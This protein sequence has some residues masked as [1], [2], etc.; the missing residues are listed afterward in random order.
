MSPKGWRVECVVEL[1]GRELKTHGAVGLYA[2]NPAM[3]QLEAANLRRMLRAQFRREKVTGIDVRLSPVDY[4]NFVSPIN[5][6]HRNHAPS[7]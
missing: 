6:K 2:D 7:R 4:A 3:N 1:N 5:A